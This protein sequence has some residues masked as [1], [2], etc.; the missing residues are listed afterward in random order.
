MIQKDIIT[1]LVISKLADTRYF[2]VDVTVSADNV[3]K[4]EIDAEDGVDIDF[5]VELNR[6]IEANF[7]REVEDYELEVGSAGLTSPFKVR[8]Q[9]EKN[10]TK[11]VEVLESNGI[12]HEGLLVEVGADSFVIEE[13]KMMRKEGDKRKK[14]YTERVAFKYSEI[15]YTKYIINFK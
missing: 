2:L 5:C 9:Y 13:T 4:V 6:F 15:K 7:D 12:K 3:I 1:N 11:E 8:R 14:A 10:L